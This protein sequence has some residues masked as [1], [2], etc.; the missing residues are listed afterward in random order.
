MKGWERVIEKEE[1]WLCFN[2]VHL[3]AFPALSL[4]NRHY[5]HPP[6]KRKKK[7]DIEQHLIEIA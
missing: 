6:T 7:R 2:F 4:K 1:H 3:A 5:L